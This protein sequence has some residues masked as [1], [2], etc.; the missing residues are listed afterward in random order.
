MSEIDPIDSTPVGEAG[1]E[2]Y[3]DE[4]ADL[5]APPQPTISDDIANAMHLD[6]IANTDVGPHITIDVQPDF[7]NILIQL[8]DH[9]VKIFRMMQQYEVPGV[10]PATI[11]AYQLQSIYLYGTIADTWLIREVTSKYGKDFINNEEYNQYLH[12]ASWNIV[13]PHLETILD[14][15]QFTFDPRRKNVAFIYSFAAFNFKHD[16][17][18]TFPIHMFIILHNIITRRMKDSTA[19]EIWLEWL[20]SPIIRNDESTVY[21]GNIIGALYN[22]NIVENYLTKKLKSLLTPVMVTRRMQKQYLKEFDI[23][24]LQFP[25]DGIECTNPYAYLLGAS[26]ENIATLMSFT[27]EFRAFFCQAFKKHTL[28]GALYGKESGTSLMNHYY[29]QSQIPTFHM[30]EIKMEDKP[31]MQTTSSFATTL[32][33]KNHDYQDSW[34]EFLPLEDVDS[35]TKSIMLYEDKKPSKTSK[36]NE[37]LQ[38]VNVN[39]DSKPDILIMSPWNTGI[40][41]LYFPVTTGLVIESEEIDGFHIPSPNIE[42]S[43]H[44]DNSS[45]LNSALLMKMTKPSY[46]FD[47]EHPIQVYKRENDNPD[48]T[49]VNMSLYDMTNHRLPRYPAMI[50]NEITDNLLPGFTKTYTSNEERAS[51]TVAFS[52]KKLKDQLKESISIESHLPHTLLAWSC[53]RWINPSQSREKD[54]ENYTYFLMNMRTNYGTFPTVVKAPHPS[55]IIP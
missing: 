46:E 42:I 13:P 44:D 52:L 28:L 33:Y 37:R 18:R 17:G 3:E 29:T 26:N 41:S 8:I 2:I 22:D 15:L 20:R 6:R 5:N 49:K 50:V 31:K 40:S 43:L 55:I 30:M 27:N 24:P 7:R 4:S 32:K 53:Y 39:R 11:L 19:D 36:H 38:S 47:G 9:S 21:V 1:K 45:I 48:T 51:N 34:T 23:E 10:T 14:G 35:Y 12:L 54:S 16:F 25:D